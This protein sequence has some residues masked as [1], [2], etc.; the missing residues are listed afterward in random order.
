MNRIYL[1]GVQGARAPVTHS[2]NSLGSAEELKAKVCS[3]GQFKYLTLP[4]LPYLSPNCS[5]RVGASLLLAAGAP[6]IVLV[7]P[8]SAGALTIALF[9]LSFW[10]SALTTVLLCFAASVLTIVLCCFCG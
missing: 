3:G 10:A 4:Y 9:S 8:F 6:T 2:M 7:L 1:W 5:V